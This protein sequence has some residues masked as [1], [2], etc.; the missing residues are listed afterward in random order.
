[1]SHFG[2]RNK[3]LAVQRRN[4]HHR[5]QHA[6]QRNVTN[7]QRPLVNR[8]F[9]DLGPNTVQLMLTTALTRGEFISDLSFNLDPAVSL[10]FGIIPL[11]GVP[12]TAVGLGVD[13]FQAD[14]DGRYDVQLQFATAGI[15]MF[16][17]GPDGCL[18][19]D[20]RGLSANSF[21]L[22]RTPD[23]SF[24][25]FVSVARVSRIFGPAGDFG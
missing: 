20:W 11:T 2:A 6:F 8:Y 18:P 22:L 14:G 1:L 25:P 3:R 19:I 10:P 16:T 13:A 12:P 7:R 24:G 15:G 9:I 4:D 23:G 17:G 5:L 21:N